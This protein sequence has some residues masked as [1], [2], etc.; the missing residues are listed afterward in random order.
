MRV[1][2]WGVRG[3]LPS[4]G[5]DTVRYGGHTSCVSVERDGVVLVLDAGSG[6]RSLGRS[7]LGGGQDIVVA[8]TH[9]H[10]DHLLGF[11]FF[12]PLYERDRRIDVLDWTGGTE[13]YSLLSMFGG[14]HVAVPRA[15]VAAVC[16]RSD[17]ALALLRKK[18]FETR[19]QRLNH[20]GGATG[21]RIEADGVAFVHLTDNEIDGPGA[22]TS[23]DE[24]VEFCRGAD[25]LSHDAQYLDA[26][27][28]EK[29]GWGHSVV[30]RVCDLAA[31][32]QVG[33]LVLFHHDPDRTDDELDAVGAMAAD[34]L[35]GDGLAC[36]P[37]REGLVLDL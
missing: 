21:W 6:I 2:Y 32:A 12:G 5:P 13:A 4:P 37:A 34:R 10:E 7:L 33:R 18:G 16:R 17:D 31:A 24:L 27:L 36:E 14:R 9:P 3:S 19:T 1:T 26:D 20:P 23:F 35:A 30:G 8:L 29:H 25:V 11:P 22:R 28:P 15:Q